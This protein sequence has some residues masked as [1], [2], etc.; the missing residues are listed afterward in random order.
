MFFHTMMNNCRVDTS[1][2]KISYT[3]NCVDVRLRGGHKYLFLFCVDGT[4]QTSAQYPVVKAKSTHVEQFT[5]A[6]NQLVLPSLQKH[7]NDE[8]SS[9]IGD[10]SSPL[11]QTDSD[12][13]DGVDAK[14]LS[15]LLNLDEALCEQ[16]LSSTGGDLELTKNR[17]TQV[18]ELSEASGLPHKVC[19][20][21][22]MQ[23]GAPANA[24][25]RLEKIQLMATMGYPPDLC[26]A[27]LQRASEDIQMAVGIIDE[28]GDELKAALDNDTHFVN[29]GDAM[30]LALELQEEFI[31]PNL[32]L[33]VIALERNSNNKALATSFL[34]ELQAEKVPH[35]APESRLRSAFT[36][37][38]ALGESFPVLVKALEKSADSADEA[39]YLVTEQV[40]VLQQDVQNDYTRTLTERM[41][42]QKAVEQ[43]EKQAEQ[44]HSVDFFG[45]SSTVERR[46]QANVVDLKQLIDQFCQV[47]ELPNQHLVVP[48]LLGQVRYLSTVC[49][50]FE[51]VPHLCD[52]LATLITTNLNNNKHESVTKAFHAM[53][54]RWVAVLSR[55]ATSIDQIQIQSSTSNQLP[56]LVIDSNMPFLKEKAEVFSKLVGAISNLLSLEETTEFFGVTNNNDEK[57]V[58]SSLSDTILSEFPHSLP[59]QCYDSIFFTLWRLGVSLQFSSDNNQQLQHYID[60]TLATSDTLKPLKIKTLLVKSTKPS[61]ASSN[62][63][64]PNLSMY[65]QG[66]KRI[67]NHPC[68][69][70]M[71]NTSTPVCF[72]VDGASVDEGATIQEVPIVK[73]A[74]HLQFLVLPV[75]FSANVYLKAVHSDMYLSMVSQDPNK[76]EVVQMAKMSGESAIRQQWSLESVGGSGGRAEWLL[77]HA[78]TGGY[79]AFM[80]VGS[81]RH[82]C[83]NFAGK[84]AF[85]LLHAE[86]KDP[87]HTHTMLHQQLSA[88]FVCDACRRKTNNIVFGFR[89]SQG[90]DY[91]L[92]KNC[93]QPEQLSQPADLTHINESTFLGVPDILKKSKEPSSV[94]CW[95]IPSKSL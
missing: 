12:T 30:K 31:S 94:C 83:V 64:M 34:K 41:K 59:G 37:Q 11:Q 88:G 38:S 95:G 82:L 23:T 7:T 33:A 61:D 32:E 45:W 73:G 87:R 1:S 71:K 39:Y 8:M 54:G 78:A 75:K 15:D 93:A 49:S 6:F 5:N 22:L 65:S 44:L 16:A 58:L 10:A 76:M 21:A 51:Y 79:M 48:V 29:K 91:D 70:C 63:D 52:K 90:C 66:I 13:Q 84:V 9:S 89:C 26:C 47:L 27:A 36:L 57:V 55:I 86:Y 2:G 42:K 74:K 56:V 14:S 46:H 24:R 19:F 18:K 67:L 4:W 60:Q 72:A 68:H 43:I 85:N 35:T 62:A 80:T 50:L 81:A 53:S 69:L 17:L 40:A 25:A 92:C 20:L 3:W 77:K 28:K